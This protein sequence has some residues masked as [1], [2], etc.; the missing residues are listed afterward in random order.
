MKKLAVGVQ[1]FPTLIDENYIY[2]DK[3]APGRFD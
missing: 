1:Y 2:V 3:T